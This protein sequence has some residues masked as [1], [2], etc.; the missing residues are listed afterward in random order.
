MKAP[1]P[2][3]ARLRFGVELETKIPASASMMVGAYHSGLAVTRALSMNGTPLA[4]PTFNGETWR[5]ERD[6]SIT[7]DPGE[8][9]CE[10]VSPIL[11]GEYGLEVLCNFVEWLSAIGARVDRS[12][13]CHITVGIESVIGSTN[14]DEISLFVRKLAHIGHWHAKGLYGQTGTGRHQNHYSHTFAED[15][16]RHMRRIV[17]TSDAAARQRAAE[18]CGRGMINFRKAFRTDASGNYIGAVEFRVFAGTINLSKILHH[19]ATVLGLC[20]RAHQVRCLGGFRKNKLQCE[21]T[22]NAVSA[23]HFLWDYLG[24][25]GSSRPVALGQFGR[26]HSGFADY[27]TEAER[28]CARFDELFP[29]VNL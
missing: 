6:G 20:R 19:L 17:R 21:R 29:N 22:Q 11:H 13:G 23:L 18:A 25:T 7:A 14:A 2:D 27:R 8:V 5:A 4:A 9:A 24:W 10:F 15:V 3:A 12:C 26:L 1:D 16:D 28:L